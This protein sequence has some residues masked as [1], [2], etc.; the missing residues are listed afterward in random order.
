MRPRPSPSAFAW[1]VQT[2][3]WHCL[4]STL[5]FRIKRAS[6]SF[7]RH[8]LPCIYILAVSLPDTWGLPTIKERERRGREGLGTKLITKVVETF[9]SKEMQLA[10]PSLVRNNC[11]LNIAWGYTVPVLWNPGCE[12]VSSTSQM[13]TVHKDVG[14]VKEVGSAIMRL[15]ILGSNWTRTFFLPPFSNCILTVKL[16]IRVTP[17]GGG[18]GDK[19][20]DK[21]GGKEGDRE[22]KKKK[23]KLTEGEGKRERP[24]TSESSFPLVVL[25]TPQN[26]SHITKMAPA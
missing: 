18:E 26:F 22:G 7:I 9:T 2:M 20:G 8:H 16:S 25:G 11:T 15:Y 21:D 12:G 6:R 1:S 19:E 14:V 13:K 23:R 10:T 17:W 4:A 3:Y 5:A 24:I